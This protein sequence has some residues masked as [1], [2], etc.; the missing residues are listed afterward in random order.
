MKKIIPFF[1]GFFLI[2]VM[3]CQEKTDIEAEKEA[4]KAVLTEETSAFLAQDL[5]SLLKTLTMNENSVYIRVD[6]KEYSE[7]IGWDKI[8]PYYKKSAKSDWSDYSDYKVSKTNWFIEIFNE[9]ALAIFDQTM[10]FKLNGEPMETHSKEI[11]VLEKIK[12]DWKIQ[13]VEWIDMS[14]FEEGE[15]VEK[16]F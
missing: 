10:S 4:I 14:S 6:S 9:A 7:M 16:E 11:R 13:M 5:V 15:V 8:Y 3:G 1:L 2:S 12:G